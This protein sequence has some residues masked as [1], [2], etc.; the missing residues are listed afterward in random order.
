MRNNSIYGVTHHALYET[1]VVAQIF[2]I[3]ERMN[4]VVPKGSLSSNPAGESKVQA[5]SIPLTHKMT[6]MEEHSINPLSQIHGH[7]RCTHRGSR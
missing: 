5:F 3:Q 6:K 4:A 1:N 7:L 2:V